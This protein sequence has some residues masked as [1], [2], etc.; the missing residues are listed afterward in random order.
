M[1]RHP[2]LPQDDL[3]PKDAFAFHALRRWRLVLAGCV[4]L[5]SLSLLS[6]FLITRREEPKVDMPI[7]SV[8]L[9]YPGASPEDVE[10]QVVKP[11][12]EVLYGMERVE[13]VESTAQPNAARF[14][15]R[16]EE[17]VNTDV[18]AEKVRG[19]IQG[20]KQDLPAEAKDP[21]VQI[22][23]TTLT[24]QMLVAVT[25]YASDAHLAAAAKG[26]KAELLTVPGVS[27]ID[28]TGDQKPAVRVRLDPVRLANHRLTVERVVEALQSANA[29][30]PGGE[31]KLDGHS[32]LLQVNQ[33]FKDAASVRDVPV[34]ASTDP[35]GGSRTVRLGDLADVTDATLTPQT[36]FLA[37]GQPGVVLELRFRA[38]ADAVTVGAAVRERLKALEPS[39]PKGLSVTL[40]H[41]QPRLITASV[42]TFVWSLLEGLLLVL[43]I[44]TL[45]MGWRPALVVSGVIPLAAGGA[46]VGLLLLGFSLE[47]VSIAGLTVALGLLVDDAVVVTESIQLMR[48]KGL[49]PARA[50]V[51]GTARVFWANN[52]TTAV[53]I[54]SFLPLFFMG[55]DIGQFIRGLPAAV[56][57]ALATSLVVAQ[58]VTPWLS[59]FLLRRHKDRPAIRDEEAFDRSGDTCGGEA[60]E[61]NRAIALLRRWYGRWIPW[62]VANPGKVVMAFC[63]LLIASLALFP[64]IGFQFFPK[65]DKP[66][67]F[68]SVEMAKGTHLD[69]TTRKV[70]DVLAILQRDRAVE[71]SSAVAGGSYPSVV[72]D[73][74][75][76]GEG[77]NLGDIMVRLRKGEDTAAVASRLRRSLSDIPGA[78]L[79]VDEIWMGP[80]V[81]HPI[82]VRIYG[83]DYEK[84][85]S[86]AEDVKRELKALPGTVNIQDSL[87]DTIPLTQVNLDADRALRRGITPAAAGQTLRW[88]Y[89]EDKVTEF[90]RGEDL[91]QVVLD[92]KPD[93]SRPLGNLEDTPL[94]SPTGQFVPLREAG[95]ATLGYG[96]AQLQR[97]DGR[98]I[99]EVSADVDSGTLPDTVLRQLDPWLKAKA[100]EPGYGFVY[101]GEQE[102]VG[103]SFTNLGLA[104][105]GAL[106]GIAVLL[107]LLFDDFV[108]AGIVVLLVPFALIGALTGLALTGNPFGF[109]AFLG[110]IALIGVFVNH[111]IYFVD[112]MLELVRRGESLEDAIRDAGQDR[113]RPVVLTALTAVLGL[114]PLTLGGGPM[115]GAFGW[116]N[117]FGLV[118]SIPLSLI[119]LPAFIV[120]VDRARRRLAGLRRE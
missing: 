68:V 70:Q 72:G 59:T 97:R 117:I 86:L 55:G 94:P 85:R 73:R 67:L 57:I 82:L 29:R 24:P 19:K 115:W 35:Q 5:L 15:V 80:P 37:Q 87:T 31:F 14:I 38:D 48:D 54:V 8:V 52:A 30:I 120:L 114:V 111:K 106:I 17:G 66:F 45:G 3:G 103:E 42:D 44:V 74:A 33:A 98:R 12:E 107:L 18:M 23:S 105:A 119:L 34:G 27:G 113:L 58:L 13:H 1:T 109:M 63:G 96:Y 11:L 60:G 36:R 99:V 75:E 9:A 53:A 20:K 51:L 10:T 21:E 89:G 116:V 118:A 93:G 92:A 110:L 16:F 84:L 78:K 32:T 65:S 69:A 50:A 62:I 102:E 28:L 26:L 64:V 2:E 39:I 4:G 49:G 61:G 100:W 43:G 46:L 40:V 88:L 90:R 56:M 112:R 25:G 79:S 6:W 7:L 41:D 83:D 81:S 47:M 108:L 101:A 95:Q 104:A 71:M 77:G 22:E 76:L 91:V